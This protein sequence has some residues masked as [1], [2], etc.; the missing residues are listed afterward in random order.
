[1]VRDAEIRNAVEDARSLLSNHGYD[2]RTTVEDFILWFQADTPYD[3]GG[4]FDS[5]IHNPLLVAHELVEIENVK[6]MGLKL[7]KDVIVKN[8]QKVDDA[9]LK[10]TRIELE[11]AILLRNTQHVSE[12][13]DNI[14]MWLEDPSVTPESK[15]QYR[16]LRAKTLDA[17]AC[18]KKE[19][20]D[21]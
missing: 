4:E 5:V 1:M 8:L 12:R 21:E 16:E 13:I 11:L 9:H 15:D 10:A 14:S 17:L 18:L 7:T 6:A 19:M 3:L 2:C 20:A